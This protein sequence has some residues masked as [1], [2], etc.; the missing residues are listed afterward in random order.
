MPDLLDW[1][2]YLG[3]LVVL[4]SLLMSSI[5]KL[6]WINLVG[7][8]IF[9]FYGF[10]IASIPTGFMNIGIAIIDIVFL[11]RMYKQKDYFRV[12]PIPEPTEYLSQFFKFYKSDIEQTQ[13]L[14]VEALNK[15]LVKFY[16]LRNMTP[17]S[18]FIADKYDSSTLEIKLDYAIPMYRDFKIGKF[19]YDNQKEY[20]SGLGYSKFVIF[21]DK[22]EHINY[23]KKM[24]FEES[25]ENKN[26]YIKSI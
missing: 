23:V 12:L 19:L 15:A 8:V 3:S 13:A 9:A 14:D 1:I 6:R 4:I 26:C 22:K 24:G 17:A 11:V 16:V 18:V 20:F 25:P 2:G 10:M 21:T 5:K 7:A